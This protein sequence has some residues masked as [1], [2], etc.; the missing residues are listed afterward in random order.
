MNPLSSYLLLALFLFCIGLY[1]AVTKR[2]IIVVL[3]CIELMLNAVN[4]NLVAFSRYGAFPSITGQVFSLF[5]IT[6]AAAE[7]AV[8]LAII[9]SFYRLKKSVDLK[10][11]DSIK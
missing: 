8:G 5:I 3:I 2:N 1:G 4:L 11:Y 7:I 9:L 6:V 10:D